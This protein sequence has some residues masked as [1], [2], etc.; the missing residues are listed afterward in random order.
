MQ[1]LLTACQGV[2]SKYLFRL[3]AG[4]LR[5]GLA[6]QSLLIALA[7]AS[8]QRNPSKSSTNESCEVVLKQ[9]YNSIPNY[10]LVIPALLEFGVWDLP[11]HC[12]M[13]PGI[14]LK[15]MLAFPTKSITQ[16]LDRF[17]G[18]P[19]TCEYKYDGERAQIHRL[20]DGTVKVFSRNSE[21]MTQKYPDVVALIPQVCTN[22][23][24]TSTTSSTFVLDC[25]V[26][27]WDVQQQKLLPFQILS[28]RK[29]KDV[30]EESIKVQVCLFAF[31]LL[32]FDGA[33]LLQTPLESR[34]ETLRQHFQQID[35]KFRFASF[36]NGTTSEDIQTFLEEAIAQSCEGL[37]VKT[38]QGAE[39]FYEPSKRSRN[40]LKLKKDYLE[41]GG[42]GLGD[43][44]DLVV[45]GG[46]TGRGKRTGVYGG[47][48]L[49]CYDADTERFQAVCKL[50]T[51]FSEAD[52]ETFSAQLKEHQISAPPAYVQVDE[53]PKPDVWFEPKVVWEVRAADFSLSPIYAAARGL[54]DEGKGVSLRFP[55]F[56]RVREDKDPE[57]ATSAEQLAEMYRSQVV[58]NS[59]NNNNNDGEDD[60]Y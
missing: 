34:R 31:D 20:A 50:G 35:G 55:R 58:I 28:T 8:A 54:V 53:V 2:E 52:L 11:K 4:K 19:F 42:S 13:Q 39:S 26:V 3:L 59:S 18:V 49:A 46:Y 17:E 5:I 43:S 60:Y 7:Q 16:V 38:L 14:P 12:Q 21:D 47:F 57:D 41:Q 36:H 40:W 29:R 48:L 22:T 6:E 45:I 1:A 25:E 44:L 27:A 33:P 9:V 10:N 51:G 37:M 30:S 15:P 32:F 24:S 23:D 56:V